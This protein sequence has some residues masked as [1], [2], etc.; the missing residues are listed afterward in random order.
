[1]EKPIA[2]RQIIF[3]WSSP[4]SQHQHQSLGTQT[5]RGSNAVDD[6][7]KATPKQSLGNLSGNLSGNSWKGYMEIILM[8]N[9]AL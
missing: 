6:E 2:L 1:V 7:K 8:I 3:R 4:T 9:V 5:R